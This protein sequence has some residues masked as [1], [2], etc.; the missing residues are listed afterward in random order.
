MSNKNVGKIIGTIIKKAK[1]N[2]AYVDFQKKNNPLS[3]SKKYEIIEKTHKIKV[4]CE[5]IENSVIYSHRAGGK[6]YEIETIFR[7]AQELN[8]TNNQLKD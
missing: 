7:L 5:S 2:K 6:Y 8:K 4:L 1:Q 3:D